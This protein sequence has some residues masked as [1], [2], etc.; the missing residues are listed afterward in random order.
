MGQLN[1]R[2]A[3][4]AVGNETQFQDLKTFFSSLT[5]NI[6]E[7]IKAALMISKYNL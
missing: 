1:P 7:N 6:C 2:L 4:Q 5:D 3:N